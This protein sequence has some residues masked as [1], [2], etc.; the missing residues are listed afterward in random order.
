MM[1]RHLHDLSEPQ[2]VDQ[3]SPSEISFACPHFKLHA[4]KTGMKTWTMIL[5]TR[6]VIEFD[7]RCSTLTDYLV[8]GGT[9]AGPVYTRHAA[10]GTR[11]LVSACIESITTALEGKTSR[12]ITFPLD[13]TYTSQLLLPKSD[14]HNSLAQ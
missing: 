6:V 2:V 12:A 8:A 14:D 13:S 7:T 1:L 3:T 5:D 4:M 10:L 11:Q 9:I